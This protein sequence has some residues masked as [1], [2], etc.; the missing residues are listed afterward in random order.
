M[1]A[2][3]RDVVLGRFPGDGLETEQ[4]MNTTIYLCNPMRSGVESYRHFLKQADKAG[5]FQAILSGIVWSGW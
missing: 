3:Q 4:Q 5:C 1:E 2:N